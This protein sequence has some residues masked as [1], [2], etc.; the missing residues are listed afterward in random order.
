MSTKARQLS[1]LAALISVEANAVSVGR[2]LEVGSTKDD[3]KRTRISSS[4]VVNRDVVANTI[5]GAAAANTEVFVTKLHVA[6]VFANGVNGESGQALVSNGTDVFWSN[7]PGYTGSAGFTGSQGTTGFTGSTGSQ[8]N[9]GF[10]G[11]LGAQGPQGNIGFTGSLGA[12]GPQGAQ[13]PIGF[14][15][16]LGAQGPQGAQGTT[17]FT[18]S[19]GN[20]G[21]FGGATFDY[22]FD[23]TTYVGAGSAGKLQFNNANVSLANTMFID[24]EQ[25][26]PFD[27]QTF[28]RTID[29][30]TSTIKGH[31]R[32]S[33]KFDTNDFALFTISYVT[34]QVDYF[35]VGCSFVSGTATSFTNQEDVIITFARTGDKGDTGFTGSTGGQ[36][37]IGFTGSLGAQGPIGFTGSLGAQGP[38]GAQGVIGFT[39]SL[40]AQGPQGAIGFTG[41]FG[42]QGPQGTQGN[43]GFTGSLGAQGPIGFTGSLGAQGPIGFTGSLGAQGPQGATGPTGPQG[44]IGFTG[45]LGAQGPQGATGPQGPIGFT[46]SLG[47]QGPQGAQGAQGATGPTGPQGPIGFTGSLGATGPQGAQGAQGAAGPTGPQGPA[48]STGP[49]GATGPTGPTGLTSGDQ[50]LAGVKTFSS[51]ILTQAAVSDNVSGLRNIHPGGGTYVTGSSNV[52]GAIKIKLPETVYPMLRFTVRIYTYDNLS[53]DIYCGGHTSSALWYNTFAYMTTQNRSALNVRFTGDGTNMYV[54]IGNLD[55]VWVYPQVFITDVQVGYTNYEY[56]RWDNGWV[57]TID[58][59]TYNTVGSTHVVYPPTSSTNNVNPAYASIFYDSNNTA[60]Y[61][62]PANLNYFNHLEILGAAHKYLYINPGNGYEAMVRYNGG[63][64][65]GWYVGKRT[66]TSLVDTTA[67]HFYSEAAGATV[68]GIDSSGNI[69]ASG[70]MRA[71]IF[72][73][74]SDT[75]YYIDPNA[76][77][78]N[79]LRMR[80]G[81]LFGPNTTWSAYLMVG[82]NGRGGYVDSATTA[83]VSVTNGNLHIDS[84]SGFNT[85]INW[86][87]GTDLLVGAGDSTTTRFRVY[88]SSD[89][90]ISSGSSR[91]PLFYDSDNTAYYTDPASTSVLNQIQF[92]PNTAQISGNDTSSYGSIAIRGARNGWYGIHIQGGGNAP[93]LMFTSANGGIYFEGTGR[94]ASYYNHG[95]NCWGFGGSGTSSAYNV[96]CPTGVYSG[97]RVDGT[98]F[99]DANNT[100]YYMD[101]NSTSTWSTSQQNGWHYFNNNYGHGIVGLYA[102]TRFQCVYAMG[103][104]YKGNADGTSLSGAYGLWW[105]YPSA[106]GPASS[107]STH[108]LLCIVNGSM[109]AQLDASTQAIGDMRAPLYYDR[110]DTGYY[111]DPN[112]TSIMNVNRVYY[113]ERHSHHTGHLR[114]GYNNI[115]A[116]EGYTSPIY[117]IGSSYEPAATTLN[118]MYGI[119]FTSGGS[120]MPSGASGWGLYV[121]DNGNARIFLSGASGNI[122]ATGNITA[123]ASDRRLKTN[124]TPISNALDKVMKIRGV[125][126]DWVDNIEE[127]GFQPQSM[128]ETGVIA[129]EIQ[130]VISDAV[131]IAPFNK[132]ATDISG[133]DNEYLTV[134]KEKIVPLLIEAIKELKAEIEELKAR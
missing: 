82:G 42:A 21:S 22:T 6:E 81:A 74:S 130:A 45:S 105:S 17:G 96:Y 95:D 115:G 69:L 43:I 101:P 32:V 63:S 71:P 134:D 118:S 119:G 100:G 88:G 79:A 2:S 46:G 16:S 78:D 9:I 102:S 83:S 20:D 38:Q 85:Y 117:C 114:G 26:G 70:S 39:G 66:S 107:L 27:I 11:S 10:T 104:A 35:E 57:I 90:T 49:Q 91:A 84:A 59:S 68:G 25:D 7:N 56:T 127:L 92:P 111:T 54:T 31:F 40:G 128:H 72:Y 97:G 121:A 103:D 36:G 44:P 126:F 122:T 1:K 5:L 125:E 112:S 34:E 37:P 87:D 14:T 15:G 129:Q 19:R 89:Y 133:V 60:Y 132:M 50:T 94:W 41:S 123:Y 76:T 86:Y 29:D 99:Y 131:R 109:Y 80:G 55:T 64:G 23:S 113:R 3:A 77:A 33:N 61:T 62:D 116:S 18:G 24:D 120:F 75:G 51:S 58:S 4:G 65:S 106:G 30:S 53:F 108:G 73:D 110:N 13:G 48:G 47:A 52:T 98:I 93:H 8:G 67:F 124:I 12:Q 28:L